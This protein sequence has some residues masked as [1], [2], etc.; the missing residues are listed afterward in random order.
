MM[1]APLLVAALLG[2]FL[3]APEAPARPRLAGHFKRVVAETDATLYQVRLF[4]DGTVYACGREGYFIWSPDTGK[5]WNSMQLKEGVSLRT[6]YW[7]TRR[8]AVVAGRKDGKNLVWRSTDKGE[9]FE[10]EDVEFTVPIRDYAFFGPGQGW[11]VAGSVQKKNGTWM[12]TKD[13]GKTFSELDSV[14]YG[15]P[16][17]PLLAIDR[18]GKEGLVA[19]GGHVEVGYVGEAAKSLLYRQKKGAVLKSK[20]AGRTWEVLDAGNPKGTLLY[21]VDFFDEKTGWVVGEEGFA[22]VTV[23]GGKTW[24]KL[25]TGTK[26]RLNA[27][28]MI[29]KEIV[30]AVGENGIAI[31][32]ND[33]GKTIVRFETDTK[34][35]LK[36]LSFKSRL[37]GF[38]V[39][40]TGTVLRFVRDY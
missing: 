37:V 32:T 8:M 34:R 2:L 31:G 33:G 24:T 40:S 17:R 18:V 29:D 11:L 25:D 5:T 30:Y 15:N 12:K 1:R 20:D 13:G 19:V 3:L 21:D 26:E 22:A 16:G 9:T 27:V 23:D 39:G 4:D 38:A 28:Q 10:Q 36:D 6:M 7:P 14:A 35:D